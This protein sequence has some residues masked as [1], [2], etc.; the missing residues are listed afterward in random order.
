MRVHVLKTWPAPYAAVLSGEKK[1]EIRVDDRAYAV[2]D[3]LE[4]VEYD[5]SPLGTTSIKRG[6][7]GRTLTVRVTYVSPG[8]TWGLPSNLCV[9]SVERMQAK[10]SRP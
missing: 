8:G 5:P 1:H 3:V 2:G 6:E 4:L 9:M 7:T 10:E